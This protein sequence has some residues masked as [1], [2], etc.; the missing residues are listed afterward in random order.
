M[1]SDAEA[2]GREEKSTARGRRRSRSIDLPTSS[3]KPH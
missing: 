1:A 2:N 3:S